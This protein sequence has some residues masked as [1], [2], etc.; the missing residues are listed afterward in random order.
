MYRGRDASNS[1]GTEGLR[2]MAL[3][4]RS[5]LLRV[6]DTQPP[7]TVELTC[8]FPPSERG[9]RP[10]T[11]QTIGRGKGPG[12]LTG[13]TRPRGA[14]SGPLENHATL[15]PGPQTPAKRASSEAG[16]GQ[17][18]SRLRRSAHP[19]ARSPRPPSRRRNPR[20]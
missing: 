14:R 2:K 12:P 11:A 6:R 8:G 19:T 13:A 18:A 7:L 1:L 16:A 10:N 3:P 5:G 17:V 9:R 15:P 20:T 4:K